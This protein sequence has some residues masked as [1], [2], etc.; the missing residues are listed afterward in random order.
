MCLWKKTP[1]KEQEEPR[2]IAYSPRN[3]VDRVM[4]P[5]CTT[6]YS[7]IDSPVKIIITPNPVKNIK[8]FGISRLG[9]IK[10]DIDGNYQKQEL[11][12]LPGHNKRVLLDNR[13]FYVTAFILVGKKWKRLWLSRLFNSNRTIH[14]LNRHTREASF[15]GE[16]PEYEGTMV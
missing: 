6:L 14:F 7:H 1:Q 10:F 15:D 8:E 5:Y 12:I 13:W 3:I 9:R 2:T 16:S 4:N 11:I